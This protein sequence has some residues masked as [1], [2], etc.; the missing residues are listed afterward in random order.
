M[1]ALEILSKQFGDLVALE[2]IKP[3]ISRIYAPFFSEDGDMLSMYLQEDSRG[4]S[5]RDL[6]ST[7]M[8]VTYTFDIDTENKKNILDGIVKSNNGRLED[9]ELIIDTD[10]EK[11]P[12]AIF[13]FSQLAA[14]VSNIDLLQRQNVKSM[15]Y[16]YLSE[17]IIDHLSAYTIKS[18]F[19]PTGD[20]EIMVDYA[21]E[22]QKPLFI[23]GVPGTT[24]AAKVV[25]GCMEFK[26][27][28]LPFR[29]II[30]HENFDSLE[31][32][33]RNRLTNVAD[34]Q[35]TN[36]ETFKQEGIKYIQD[37]VA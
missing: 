29:S 37:E 13:Q 32:Y 3:G 11:L 34:K 27:V 21:I 12:Q 16:D 9:G 35:Y 30:V 6:G 1:K 17:F 7:L 23:F 14:K 31:T 4:F 8:K 33:Y 19:A 22:A 26:R 28:N 15:F 36:L 5:I 20:R 25:I 10:I 2:E 24:K 18:N